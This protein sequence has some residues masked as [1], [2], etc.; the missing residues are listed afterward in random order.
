MKLAFRR[1]SAWPFEPGVGEDVHLRESFRVLR[2]K[3]GEVPAG[4]ATRV[5]SQD[6]LNLSDG[7]LL[8]TWTECYRDTSTGK[9][10]S[11]RGWYHTLYCDIF[12]G[13][14]IMDIGSGLGIDGIVY[15]EHGAEVTFVD[16]A[17][18]NL[19]LVERVCKIKGLS[20]TRFCYLEDLRA[21][22]QLPADYD[23][24]YCCGSLI[25]APLEVVRREAQEFLKHLPVSGRW[26]ELGYPRERWVRDGRMSFREWGRKTDGGAPWVEWHDLEKIQGFLA[27]AKF[28]TVLAF[29]FHNND[30]NWFDLIR[31]A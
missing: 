19:H 22:E 5:M 18:P 12:C 25:H 27:P 26:I 15:A 17:R 30:F 11:V 1:E 21:L 9:A 20:R 24:I 8:R 7:D 3:W 31:R 13:K 29:N 10:H 14:K 2:T 23:A 16:L 6:L 4:E 28:D